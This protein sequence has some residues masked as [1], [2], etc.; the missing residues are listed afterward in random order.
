[1]IIKEQR[2]TNLNRIYYH[3]QIPGFDN[4]Q[5]RFSEFYLTTKFLYSL[6]YAYNENHNFGKVELYRLNQFANIFNA[7]S[8]TDEANFRKYLQ[9]SF[10]ECLRCIEQLKE[11]DW[12]TI[13]GGDENRKKLLHSVKQ[14]GYDG[15][16]NYEIDKDSID[17]LHS[18]D[19]FKFSDL[20][21]KSPSIGIFNKDIL[22]KVFEYDE[23]NIEKYPEFDKLK[24]EE[25]EYVNSLAKR[26]ILK[27]K[28]NFDEDMFIDNVSKLCVLLSKEEIFNIVENINLEDL[29]EYLNKKI[30]KM[31]NLNFRYH[32]ISLDKDNI[33]KEY[34]SNLKYLEDK[35]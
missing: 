8:K 15:Y 26:S 17:E 34:H 35:I 6:T 13:S 30:Q 5:K 23:N 22:E 11:N 2:Y 16:F 32:G 31:K 10:P 1:M 4:N 24:N 27:Y 33:L 25:I 19:I 29:K 28:D 20:V 7:K 21:V 9:N 14:L 3:G 18:Y 12:S